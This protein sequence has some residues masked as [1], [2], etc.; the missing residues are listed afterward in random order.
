LFTDR[1]IVYRQRL[2]YDHLAVALSVGVQRLVRASVR[3]WAL[4][5]V[6]EHP[7]SDAAVLQSP[8]RPRRSPER[9]AQRQDQ[10][11]QGWQRRLG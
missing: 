11:Q 1:A 7:A 2:G 3:V 5:L 6:A 9:P 8:H 10:Q 4:P